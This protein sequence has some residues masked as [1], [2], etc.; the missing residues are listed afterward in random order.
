MSSNLPIS[1]FRIP[2]EFYT[3]CYPDGDN[4]DVVIEL[5]NNVV[6]IWK[7]NKDEWFSHKPICCWEIIGTTISIVTGKQSV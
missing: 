1:M 5:P 6:R 3:L 4:K 7:L 2:Q